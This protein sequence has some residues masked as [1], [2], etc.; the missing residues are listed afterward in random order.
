MTAKKGMGVRSN[1]REGVPH[2]PADPAGDEGYRFYFPDPEEF[3]IA[4]I[5]AKQLDI[6][7][8]PRR[9][10]RVRLNLDGT[11]P[12]YALPAVEAVEAVEAEAQLPRGGKSRGP[13]KAP[14]SVR[15]RDRKAEHTRRML[16][17]NK[18]ML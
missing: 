9:A 16:R 6:A 7:K 12:T 8:C 5:K 13:Q 2:Y 10:W 11:Q 17:A 14:L 18:G 15:K 1:L 4:M 3:R